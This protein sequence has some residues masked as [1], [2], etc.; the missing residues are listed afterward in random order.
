VDNSE[1]A[2]N[3]DFYPT[4]WEAQEEAAN[5]IAQA[6]CDSNPESSVGLMMMAGKQYNLNRITL[7]GLG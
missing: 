4:R 5:L 1:W 2:R 7:T 6:K 3:G